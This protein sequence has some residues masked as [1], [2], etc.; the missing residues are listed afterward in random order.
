MSRLSASAIAAGGSMIYGRYPDGA[1]GTYRWT[2]SGGIRDMHIPGSVTAASADGSVFTGL[3]FT[4]RGE[5]V[6]LWSLARGYED[7]G[8]PPGAA[9]GNAAYI[10]PN[11]MSA[12]GSTVVGEFVVATTKHTRAFRWTRRG[13]FQTLVGDWAE[14]SGVSGDGSQIVG[15]LWSSK[16]PRAVKWVGDASPKPI[17]PSGLN[18]F[19]AKGISADGRTIIAIGPA[20]SREVRSFVVG[21]N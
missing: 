7:L 12:D 16:G 4:G 13:G 11:A 14:A 19:K 6:F 2:R 17:G 3:R 20:G 18:A 1:R 15:A 21:A 5:H 8:K 10:S 9:T